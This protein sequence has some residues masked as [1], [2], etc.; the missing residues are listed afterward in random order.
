MINNFKNIG[1]ILLE[2]DGFYKTDDPIAKRK[3]LLHHQT[4][5]PYRKRDNQGNVILDGKAICLNFNFN[6][7]QIDFR[8]SKE[9]IHESNKDI[10]FAFRLGAPGDKK[11]FLSTNSLDS[12]F[13]NLFTQSMDYIK[14]KRNKNKSRSWFEKNISEGYEQLMGKILQHF[15]VKNNEVIL[16]YTKL[17]TA[18]KDVFEQ[19]KI[20]L[21]DRA[22]KQKSNELYNR[23][24]NKLFFNSASKSNANFPAICTVRINDQHIL[25][26]ENGKF[27][28]DYINLCYYDLMERFFIEDVKSKKNCHICSKTR[29]VI[30]KIPFSMKF[31]GT[32][33]NLNFENAKNTNAYKSFAICKECFQKVATGMKHV[34]QYF[35]EYLFDMNYYLL[36]QIDEGIPL[37]SFKTISKLLKTKKTNYE[38]EITNIRSVLRR[39]QKRTAKFDLFFFFSPPGSQQFDILQY[40]SS[41]DMDLLLTKLETFDHVSESY[42]LGKIGRTGNSLTINDLR[43]FLFPS[44]L[45]HSNPDPKVFRKDLL[46]FLGHFL[47]DNS[48][49]YNE[50][51]MRFVNIYKKRLNR[52]KVDILSPFKM[53][54]FLT[55]MLKFE[56]IKKG[57]RVK[58]GSMVS[59][60][61][62]PE[63]KE[64]FEGHGEIYLEHSFRQGLFLLGTVI[65][66]IKYKQKDKSSN[67]LKKLNFGGMP[68]RRIP[69][70]I[71]QVKEFSE[72]YKIYE[73]PGIWGNI[74]DRLQG[75]HESDMKPDEILFYILTGI[76]FEDY[77]GMK[78]SYDKQLAEA[79]KQ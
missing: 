20:D 35:S 70:L 68:A 78:Y 61:L 7:C 10:F 43:F 62:K 15:Y 49:S 18:Q 72:I 74:M 23:F 28:N 59:K 79:N 9:D 30:Q 55:I 24:L 60:I 47:S 33:N 65:S 58:K 4:L 31:Y 54:L 73:E 67:F 50:L 52:D 69:S 13:S 56:K 34:E 11:K 66:K 37:D 16:D 26:F 6:N 77:L 76:S 21:G 75:I 39:A 27:E 57:G 38:G 22:E 51:I 17:I 8:L 71:G 41:I 32:T 14:E 3:I 25:E 46:N 36:P 53:V 1:E 44:Y 19:M 45:S 63:Y 29:D 2:N 42:L 5:K 48:L 40:I 64:F 12:F